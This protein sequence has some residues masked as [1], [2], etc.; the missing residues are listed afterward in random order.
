MKNFVDFV[1]VTET[2]ASGNTMGSGEVATTPTPYF[3]KS[4]FGGKFDDYAVSHDHYE[5]LKN[6]RDSGSRWKPHSLPEDLESSLRNSLYTDGA[7]VVT[8]QKTGSSVILRHLKLLRQM[9]NN[10]DAT[11]MSFD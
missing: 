10:D 1:K 9:R 7:A 2:E 8:S 5:S 3:S 4:R 11:T 6:G